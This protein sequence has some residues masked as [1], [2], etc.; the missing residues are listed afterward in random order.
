MTE[1]SN[2]TPRPDLSPRLL[3]I[4]VAL[5]AALLMLAFFVWLDNRHG[6]Q[7][8]EAFANFLAA[9]FGGLSAIWVIVAVLLQRAELR[10]Q[11]DELSL[12]REELRLQRA[13]STRL[14]NEA[15]NQ[16]EALK[17]QVKITNRQLMKSEIV[18]LFDTSFDHMSAIQQD[19]YT[20][21]HD[22]CCEEK[23]ISRHLK[24]CQLDFEATPSKLTA[25]Y[26]KSGKEYRRFTYSWP[27]I[28]EWFEYEPRLDV[29]LSIAE[30]ADALGLRVWY[31][32]HIPYLCEIKSDGAES[33]I[34]ACVLLSSHYAHF[35]W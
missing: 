14:A 5:T 30:E 7:E 29:L 9:I 13:E 6:F 16:A 8:A 20:K 10:L 1:A 11:R 15:A 32:K 22:K 21:F 33:V 12:Q 35:R 3:W 25:V 2:A 24:A 18:S 31:T 4:G 19:L 27:E 17:A 26:T 23:K 34:L 28:A